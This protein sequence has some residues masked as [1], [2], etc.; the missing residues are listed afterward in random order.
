M[1]NERVVRIGV[2]NYGAT[3]LEGTASK[4]CLG[5]RTL[6]RQLEEYDLKYRDLVRR[7]RMRR[8]RELLAEPQL[9]IGQIGRLVGYSLSPH[10]TRAFTAHH[11]IA[12]QEFRRL[13]NR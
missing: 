1:R 7:R 3:D 10:F 5:P 2:G 13:A 4:L 6:Q 8:A 12:P 9:S 11:G